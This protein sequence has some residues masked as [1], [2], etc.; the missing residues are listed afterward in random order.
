MTE[1]FEIKRQIQ[2]L[3]DMV[4]KPCWPRAMKMKEKDASRPSESIKILEESRGSDI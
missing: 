3:I 2:Y 4:Y 1:G